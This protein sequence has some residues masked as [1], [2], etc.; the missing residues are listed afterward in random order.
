MTQALPRCPS[1][2]NGTTRRCCGAR[3][4][5]RSPKPCA[6]SRPR[7]P[8]EPPARA[9]GLRRT[10]GRPGRAGVIRGRVRARPGQP[11]VG[12]S[13]LRAKA[14]RRFGFALTASQSGAGGN[15]RRPG[16]PAPHAAAA[17]RRCRVRQ[18]PGRAAGDAARGGGRQAGR[19][20]GAHRGAGQAAPSHAVAPVPVPVA[21]LTGAIK[22]R[23]APGCCAA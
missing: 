22:G 14:L 9:P 6:R 13:A 20:D 18:D 5:P 4:G 12:D 23:S 2:P 7:G 16:L 11:L 17:A 10:A 15:R 19:P 3:N 21:L 8:P 1:F